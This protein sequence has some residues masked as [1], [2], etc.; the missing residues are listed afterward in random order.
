MKKRGMA[1]WRQRTHTRRTRRDRDG[2]IEA[3]ARGGVEE[4]ETGIAVDRELREGGARRPPSGSGTRAVLAAGEALASRAHPGGGA[5][6]A[7][8][9]PPAPAAA[10]E[11]HDR[12]GA[13]GE[14]EAARGG[15]AG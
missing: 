6:C 7:G 4:I 11:R 8:P 15:A 3:I 12:G 2:D 1:R 13:R 14:G 10:W 5:T 9:D